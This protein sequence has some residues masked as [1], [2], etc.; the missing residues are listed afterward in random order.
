MFYRKEEAKEAQHVTSILMVGDTGVGKSS[1]L[2]QMIYKSYNPQELPTL[3][4]DFRECFVDLPG[5]RG[6]KFRIWDAAGETRF[7]SITSR[8]YTHAKCVLLVYN[9]CD[10]RSFENII[11]W[12]Q[13]VLQSFIGTIPPPMILVGN[14]ID[15]NERVI[16]R[17]EGENFAKSLGVDYFETSAVSS[18][19][20][21]KLLEFIAERFFYHEQYQE[22]M[23]H[24][25][26]KY[27]SSSS[28]S[29]NPASLNDIDSCSSIRVILRSC[30][31][32]S[33]IEKCC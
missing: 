26:L 5:N 18:H 32:A 1:I 33:F 20:C 19:N 6:I 21:A 15:N 24:E 8:Y 22:M 29:K 10:Q 4:I 31:C 14:Q 17:K 13:Q 3:G 28:S 12:R 7:Q 16:T 30:I 2:N 23:R 25:L 9:V 27:R 11:L